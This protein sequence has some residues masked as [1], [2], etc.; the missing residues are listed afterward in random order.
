MEPYDCF[1]EGAWVEL[2]QSPLVGFRGRFVGRVSHGGLVIRSSL[3]QQLYSSTL[4][5]ARL[6]RCREFFLLPFFLLVFYGCG[7]TIGG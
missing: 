2:K 5:A 4:E 6:F 3:L 7:L 1:T